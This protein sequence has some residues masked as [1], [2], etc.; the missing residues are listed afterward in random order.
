MMATKQ[1]SPS[2]IEIRGAGNIL[3]PEQHGHLATV[4]Y[5]MYCKLME[6]TL[7][8]ARAEQEG[9]P[10][11]KPHLETRVDI[12]VDAYL[13]PDIVPLPGHGSWLE[14]QYCKGGISKRY[15]GCR[16]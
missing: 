14:I 13:P 1:R 10:P 7:Q 9:L 16:S 11:A 2:V 3:G 5:D 15:P 4:G 6:E 12:K 8:E